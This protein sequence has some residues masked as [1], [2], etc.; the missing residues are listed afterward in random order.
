MALVLLAALLGGCGDDGVR[1]R[2]RRVQPTG[3]NSVPLAV[4]NTWTYQHDLT[5]TWTNPDGSDALPPV[6]LTATGTRE[7][8]GAETIDGREYALEYQ[9]IARDD[10]AVAERWRRFRQDDNALY[11]AD[12]STSIPPGE[13]DAGGEEIGEQLRLRLP[14]QVGDTWTLRPGNDAIVLT[15]EEMETLPLAFGDTPAYRVRLDDATAGPN[16]TQFLWYGAAGL[17]RREAHT[18]FDAVDS[19]TG[20]RVHIVFN[21]IEEMTDAELVE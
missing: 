14:L 16:G 1:P 20:E 5:R 21:E 11:R 10:G 12:V 3:V 18:E 15:V 13:V 17:L 9:R 6:H 19:L 2:T 7:I 4:G 8:I